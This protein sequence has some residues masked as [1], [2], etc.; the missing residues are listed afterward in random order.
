M[1]QI[2]VRMTCAEAELKFFIEITDAPQPA[3]TPREIAIAANQP[4]W[5]RRLRR[6]WRRNL[7]AVEAQR[8]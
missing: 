3:P 5:A 2:P 4:W 8:L 7:A 1:P 6:F